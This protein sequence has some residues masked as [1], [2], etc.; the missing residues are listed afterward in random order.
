LFFNKKSRWTGFTTSRPGGASVHGGPEDR[1]PPK[2]HRSA[3][4]VDD[5]RARSSPRLQKKIE[6][7]LPVLT[8]GFGDRGN[9][10]VRPTAIGDTEK[11]EGGEQRVRCG[12]AEAGVRFIGPGGGGEEGR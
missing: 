2:L 8:A 10:G 9:G 3:G 6:G 5:A 12:D 11:S 7:I 4:F 1:T